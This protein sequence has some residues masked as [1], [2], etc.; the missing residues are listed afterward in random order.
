[1]CS[2]SGTTW[3]ERNVSISCK[4]VVVLT[5]PAH[6][7]MPHAKKVVRQSLCRT[8]VDVYALV[9]CEFADGSRFPVGMSK[10]T[11]S[12]GSIL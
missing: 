12:G 7:A 9:E 6:N 8:R 2:R 5:A 3:Y 4:G 1:M 10:G 11:M